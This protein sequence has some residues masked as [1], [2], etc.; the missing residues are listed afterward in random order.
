M[1]RS[2]YDVGSDA[3]NDLL[4]NYLRHQQIIDKDNKLLHYN[5]VTAYKML[6]LH[7]KYFCF[8]SVPMH[9]VSSS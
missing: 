2:Q 5:S 1:I 6:M 3:S 9:L 7:L 4:I 8:T